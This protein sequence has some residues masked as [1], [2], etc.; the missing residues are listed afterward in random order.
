MS[1]K[2]ISKWKFIENYRNGEN[3]KCPECG[4]ELKHTHDRKTTRLIYCEKCGF[5]IYID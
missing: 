5:E 1:E 2:S 3:L 4:N